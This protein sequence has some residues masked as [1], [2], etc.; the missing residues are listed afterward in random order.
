MPPMAKS[1]GAHCSSDAPDGDKKRMHVESRASIVLL[2]RCPS[3]HT[4][5]PSLS[6]GM[7]AACP[8]CPD[9][10]TSNAQV[11]IHAMQVP[12]HAIHAHL[13]LTSGLSTR[14]AE[15][16]A[17]AALLP[18]THHRTHGGDGHVL[19]PGCAGPAAAPAAAAPG[20]AG[21]P[22]RQG[23]CVGVVGGEDV[24]MGA[25]GRKGACLGVV[26][27]E[28]VRMGAPGR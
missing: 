15:P 17:A 19:Q 4:H 20:P 12:I 13:L 11:L 22:G 2:P 9:A 24:R 28:D 18:G 10:R 6:P 1:R 5:G 8:L 26:G 3:Y 14:H 7:G 25:P 16:L 21:A 23:A 27:G